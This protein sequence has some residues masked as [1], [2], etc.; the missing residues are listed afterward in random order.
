MATVSFSQV[1]DNHQKLISFNE[2]VLEKISN[3]SSSRRRLLRPFIKYF[4]EAHMKSQYERLSSLYAKEI[5]FNSRHAERTPDLE[6]L[7]QVLQDTKNYSESLPSFRRFYGSIVAFLSAISALARFGLPIIGLDSA[8]LQDAN[9]FFGWIV[10]AILLFII[11]GII[12]TAFSIKRL[13]FLNT[14]TSKELEARLAKGEHSL[15]DNIYR[16]ENEL[17]ISLGSRSLKKT[18]FPLDVFISVVFGLFGVSSLL[19]LVV[20]IR[21]PSDPGGLLLVVIVIVSAFM[22]RPIF[23]FH[24]RKSSHLV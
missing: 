20:S 12:H 16:V 6:K 13:L 24:Q 2:K 11:G 8:T 7:R 9:I 17:Y 4:A 1:I 18:E 5:L 3:F 15:T 21:E 22:V 14:R 23:D 19:L 10:L